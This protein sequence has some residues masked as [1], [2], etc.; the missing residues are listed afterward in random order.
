MIV[1][2]P[3]LRIDEV[4]LSY[5]A[6]VELLQQTIVNILQK[7]YNISYA[8]AYKIWYKSQIKVNP[9]VWNIIECIIEDSERGIPVLINRKN[10]IAA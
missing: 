3:K 2:D 10:N 7:S 4:T 1:P 6:L 5:K 9:R 8:D